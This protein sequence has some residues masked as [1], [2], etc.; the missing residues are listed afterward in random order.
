MN[1]CIIGNNNSE[2]PSFDGGRAKIR[3]IRSSIQLLGHSVD[4]LDLDNWKR[5]PISILFKALHS[6]K[7]YDVV[8]IMCAANGSRTL[9]RLMSR[10][11][12]KSK[13]VFCPIGTGTVNRITAKYLN[14]ADEEVF[15]SG[16][17]FFC[18]KDT[19]IGRCLSKFDSVLVENMSLKKVYEKFYGLSNV[20]LLTNFR[21]AD[22]M[23]K[24][25]CD[26]SSKFLKCL[27]ISRII[28]SKGI[29]NLMKVI[30][31]INK[32][33]VEITL[34]IYG[35]IGLEGDALKQFN[36]LQGEQIVY[37]GLLDGS[38]VIET[39]NKYDLF[40]FPVISH[41]GTP[42]VI[43]ESII[44]C[45]PVLAPSLPQISEFID[46]NVDG[47]IYEFGSDDALFKKMQYILKNRDK[48][49][50]MS[51]PLMKKAN[52]YTFAGN[53]EHIKKAFFLK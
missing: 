31:D 20:Q 38:K 26:N 41:E 15:L 10:A 11:R 14:P 12:R 47:F 29:L 48:L 52:R 18:L 28:P 7:K 17:Y 23:S 43:A 49:C 42:G 21:L 13:L 6:L 1:V 36:S 32:Q 35:K 40:C 4:V 3:T 50:E 46:D 25:K 45:T 19:T 44:A 33:S 37:K 27:F 53:V 30:N 24:Q 9:A 22:V 16:E 51:L 5:K 34:D 2:K 8:I 39:I